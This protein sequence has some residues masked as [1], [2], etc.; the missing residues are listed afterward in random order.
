[1]IDFWL[2]KSYVLYLIWINSTDRIITSNIDLHK[3]SEI[4]KLV[5]KKPVDTEVKHFDNPFMQ[6][7][8]DK[9]RVIEAIKNGKKLSTLKGIKVASPI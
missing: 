8:E 7:I 1:M 2:L 6:M 5:N 3:N 4:M 9:K